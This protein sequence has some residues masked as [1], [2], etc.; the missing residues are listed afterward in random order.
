MNS[1]YNHGIK[2]TQQLTKDLATFEKNISTSPLSLQ[3]SISTSLTAFK[4][5]I[6]E[7]KDLVQNTTIDEN[8]AKQELRLEKFSQELQDFQTK[9]DTLRHQRESLIQESNTQELFGRRHTT[10]ASD[11]PYEQENNQSQAHSQAQAQLSYAEGMYKE[12]LSLGRGSERLD[13]ILEMGQQAFED[14]VDQNEVLRKLQSKFESSL[15]TLGVSQETIRSVNRRAKQ[16]KYLF[17]GCVMIMVVMFYF[18]LKW[19]R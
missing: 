8:K 4:K 11:N 16:D 7:Y 3:G 2:Q 18:I 17:W 1:L 6:K 19:F 14:I 10:T 15:I 5:T 13:Q 12:K 9:F